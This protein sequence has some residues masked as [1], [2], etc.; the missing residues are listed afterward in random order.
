MFKRIPL[1]RK[2]KKKKKKKSSLQ[3]KKPQHKLMT[4]HV[5]IASRKG[6]FWPKSQTQSA[7][8]N[9]T[10][11][12]IIT[13]NSIPFLRLYFLLLLYS[14]SPL[15]DSVNI[16]THTQAYAKVRMTEH[17]LAHRWERPTD[18]P[19]FVPIGVTVGGRRSW[20]GASVTGGSVVPR[21]VVGIGCGHRHGHDP[22]LEGES[23]IIPLCTGPAR[24]YFGSKLKV[25]VGYRGGWVG[26]VETARG[27]RE[28]VRDRGC[29]GCLLVYRGYLWKPV[30]EDG[31]YYAAAQ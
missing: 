2:N 25:G 29:I 16:D 12:T 23:G 9:P 8:P 13:R 6:Y 17:T 30:H 24:P 31:G 26:V 14:C 18:D 1:Y 21:V 20:G 5:D 10:F 28:W 27:R 3:S 7:H 22:K 19:S 15:H 4:L 11:Q